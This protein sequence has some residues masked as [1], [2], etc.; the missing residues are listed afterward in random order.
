MRLKDP[1]HMLDIPALLLTAVTTYTVA[2]GAQLVRGQNLLAML[3]L[4][5]GV[6]G[7]TFLLDKN[8]VARL[9]TP[10]P[11][12]NLLL[13]ILC[14]LPF[15]ALAVLFNAL[16]SF[17][18]IQPQI[19]DANDR[20]ALR[21]YWN[22][23]QQKLSTFKLALKVAINEE[24]VRLKR[25]RQRIEA[26]RRA[27]EPY[28][29]DEWL[30]VRQQT[31][32]IQKLDKAAGQIPSLSSEPPAGR[33]AAVAKVDGGYKDLDNAAILGA[34]GP[35]AI[36]ALLGTRPKPEVMTQSAKDLETL[37]WQE[38]KRRSWPVLTAWLIGAWIEF[39]PLLALLSGT[40]KISAGQRIRGYRARWEE[41]KQAWSEP[42]EDQAIQL[43]IRFQPLYTL[44]SIR[45]AAASPDYALADC[46]GFLD[47]AA[48]ALGAAYG[49]DYHIERVT[50]EDDVDIDEDL[51]LEPQL[52]GKALVVYVESANR[53]TGALV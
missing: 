37:F 15:F 22:V 50:N 36:R 47:E 9:S 28:S 31:E 39:L 51:P 8:L 4:G 53:F 30:A 42:A 23:E 41:A 24:S 44:A 18:W 46:R 7:M 34:R 52:A 11:K 12:Q 16:C 2:K 27:G 32:L 38:T 35:E 26:A 1:S 10:R 13:L 21:D 19:A 17:E 40:P 29:E 33:A 14:W 5:I 6:A 48:A 43:A 45:I 25:E 49:H 3:V 20:A